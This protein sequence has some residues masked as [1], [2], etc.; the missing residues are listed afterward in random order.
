MVKSWSVVNSIKLNSYRVFSTRKDVAVS[1]V[2]G[3]EHEFFV[4]EA[5]DWINVIATTPDEHVVLIEQ[6]RHGIGSVT[7]EIP[8][9]MIDPGESPLEAARRELL[10]E[11]GFSS[12][13]WICLGRVHPNPAIQQNVCYTFLARNA[14]KSEEPSLEDT[15]DIAS[16]LVPLSDIRSLI[17][18]GKITHSLV[19]AAFYWYD[20]YRETGRVFGVT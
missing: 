7:L 8:G 18:K 9:G 1:P 10:E 17:A 6:Y 3:R 13:E 12:E 14:R 5:P 2:T 20:L 4:I 16:L 11:T 19:I 15:E